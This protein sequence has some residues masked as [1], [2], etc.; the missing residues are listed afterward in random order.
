MP[1]RIYSPIVRGSGVSIIHDALAG[2]IEGYRVKELSSYAGVFPVLNLL[3]RREPA[4]ITHIT[5]E[6]GPSIAHPDSRVVATFHNYY[7]DRELQPFATP[8]QRLFYQTILRGAVAASLR[9][10]SVITAVSR[11]IADL[12]AREH[13]PSERLICLPNGID[14]SQF[15]PN[16]RQFID[17]IRI[18]FAGNPTRRKGAQH[19]RALAEAL[20]PNVVI[21]YTEGLRSSAVMALAEQPKLQKI[22]RVAHSQMHMIYQ[23]SDIFFFPTVREGFGLVVAEAMACGLPVVV[24]NCSSMPE[25]VVHGK[26]GFLFEPGNRAQMLEYLL[27]LSR[28]PGLRQEMGAFN[29]ERVVREFPLDRMIKGYRDVF[30]HLSR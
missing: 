23:D 4:A 7:L 2:G 25:L 21:R 22:P 11:F 1:T 26:G 8:S 20:P 10:A 30:E 16:P 3:R 24:S 29:R 28:E 19:L 13:G 6:F 27:R 17:E 18:L 15:V 12:V 5:A 14:T 9:R